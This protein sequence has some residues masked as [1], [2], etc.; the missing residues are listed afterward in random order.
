VSDAFVYLMLQHRLGIADRWFPLLPLGTA[1]AFLLL[2]LPLG[3]LAD[4]VGRRRV[5]LAG[6]L[7]LFLAYGLLLAPLHG[8]ALPFVVLALH[9]TFYAATD[10][11]LPA[12]AAGAVPAELRASGLALIGTGQA[13]ARLCC[14]I[15]FGAAWTAI[16]D[17]AALGFAMAG[18]A[19]CAGWAA[20]ALRGP[21]TL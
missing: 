19:V 12:A 4:R 6:H 3:M 15:A 18:L 17:R 16:G 14:S 21:E 8:E 10:G 13:L 1:A 2:A 9:G 11:V 5:F 7:A 20:Y